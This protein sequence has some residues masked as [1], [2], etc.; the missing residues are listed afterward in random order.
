MPHFSLTQYLNS[1][2]YNLILTL[3]CYLIPQ[4][5]Q[6]RVHLPTCKEYIVIETNFC[7]FIVPAWGYRFQSRLRRFKDL[8]NFWYMHKVPTSN[9]H[10]LL[11]YIHWPHMQIC[12]FDFNSGSVQWNFSLK[13]NCSLSFNGF[14]T[15]GLF[16]TLFAANRPRAEV[17]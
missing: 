9:A 2:H 8:F 3:T 12:A 15:S 4:Y 17:R 11:V 7:W 5:M 1:V 13:N 14:M 16:E 10:I 6:P